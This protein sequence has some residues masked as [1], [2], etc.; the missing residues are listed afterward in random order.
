MIKHR[1]RTNAKTI[2]EKTMQKHTKMEPKWKL[3]SIKNQTNRST[4]CFESPKADPGTNGAPKWLLKSRK[5][6]GQNHLKIDAEQML[7]IM[8]KWHRTCNQMYCKINKF[9]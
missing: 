3:K 1:S 6:H 5:W 4:E 2:E 9:I 8:V 7:K